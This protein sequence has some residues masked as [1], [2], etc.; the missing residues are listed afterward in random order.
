MNYPPYNITPNVPGGGQPYDPR[1][2]YPQQ[3]Q[4]NQ[5]GN[6]GMWNASPGFTCRPV[7]S[8]EEA[9]AAQ[10]DFFGPGTIMPDLGH[11]MIYLKRFNTT[12]G[13][14]DFLAF[15]YCPPQ[16][17]AVPAPPYDPRPEI[18]ALRGELNALRAELEE[19]KKAGTKKTGGKAE[20]K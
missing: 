12:T 15:S 9:V 20:E 3:T 11:G 4:Q 18:E 10:V 2:G 1:S 19:T 8:R 13:E 6:P 17:P 5:Q 16:A 14:S 7:T